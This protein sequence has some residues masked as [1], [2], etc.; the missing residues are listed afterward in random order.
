MVPRRDDEVAVEGLARSARIG[1]L[2]YRRLLRV[3]ALLAVEV[4]FSGLVEADIEACWHQLGSARRA[5][6]MVL[7][8]THSDVHGNP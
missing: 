4:E 5:G 7:L 3:H 8:V 2:H 6:E 1:P